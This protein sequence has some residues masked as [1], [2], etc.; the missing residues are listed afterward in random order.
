MRALVTGAGGFL[1]RYVARLLL[2]RGD[3]VVAFVRGDYPELA[4]RGARLVRGD[5]QDGA[6]IREA[7]AGVEAVYHVASKTG[8]WGSWDEFYGANVVGTQNVIAACSSTNI[9][10]G[11]AS[12]LQEL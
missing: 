1:G 7:C 8:F 5:L 9:F 11:N 10:P 3:E 12:I 6:A 4:A 2:E